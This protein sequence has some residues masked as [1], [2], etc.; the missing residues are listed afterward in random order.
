GPDRC[1]PRRAG[2]PAL[3]PMRGATARPCAGRSACWSERAAATRAAVPMPYYT[4]RAGDWRANG[5]PRGVVGGV[6]AVLGWGR[7]ESKRYVHVARRTFCS[8]WVEASHSQPYRQSLLARKASAVNE[9]S[10]ATCSN[11]PVPPHA[12]LDEASPEVHPKSEL[13]VS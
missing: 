5:T 2:A 10:V 6:I 12:I 4:P 8:Q 11:R 13:Y 1:A 9:V 3:A 7:S